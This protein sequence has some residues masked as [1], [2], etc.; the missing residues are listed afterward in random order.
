MQGELPPANRE[1]HDWELGDWGVCWVD[2]SLLGGI[3]FAAGDRLVYGFA[4]GVVDEGEGGAGIG[5]GFVAGTGDG[6]AGY[7]GGGAVEHP[8]ALGTV[9]GR[10]VWGLAAQ[11]F[12]VDVAEGVEG[13][14]FVGVIGIFDGAEVGGEELGGLW[15][16]VLGDHVLDGGLNAV[17]G[18]GVDGSE[19]ETEESVASV[20]L[21]LGGEGFGQLDG[22][23]LDDDAANVDDVCSD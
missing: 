19:G 17:R 12:L 9:H 11:G 23:V 8:E 3:V 4:G 5:D 22:L 2:V 6:L 14:T 1:A 18:D 7:N 10:V 16:V 15:D 13:F 21:E 20:L